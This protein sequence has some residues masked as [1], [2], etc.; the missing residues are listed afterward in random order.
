MTQK[1]QF[2]KKFLLF[3]LLAKSSLEDD[4]VTFEM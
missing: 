2:F 3:V 1:I 4:N